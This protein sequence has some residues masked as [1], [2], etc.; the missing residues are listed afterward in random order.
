REIR[1][2]FLAVLA[3]QVRL[4]PS[5]ATRI[6]EDEVVLV[7]LTDEQI[8]ILDTLAEV[9]R[10]A[11]KGPA[12]TGKT[13]VAMEKGRRLAPDGNRVLFLCFNRPLAEFLAERAG[14]FT[15]KNFHA[16]CRELATAAGLPWKP[17]KQRAAAK[18]YLET[19]PPQR[20]IEALDAYPDERWDSVI[21]D[22]G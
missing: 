4:V 22:E 10:I 20:L 1:D 9:P 5:L 11:V 2:R 7:R 6:E 19:E 18:E 13:L 15:V 3:P 14:N 17:P 8:H 21:V 12:G 16:L